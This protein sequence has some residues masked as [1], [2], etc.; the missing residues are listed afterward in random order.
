MQSVHLEAHVQSC[1]HFYM[2]YDQFYDHVAS[3]VLACV[4]LCVCV[5]GP[6]LRYEDVCACKCAMLVG[7]VLPSLFVSLKFQALLER[8]A[9]I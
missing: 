1:R 8:N 5:R 4:C 9:D 2:F 3:C 7:T 6:A